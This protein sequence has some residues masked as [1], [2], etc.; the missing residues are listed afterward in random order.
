[1]PTQR[2]KIVWRQLDLLPVKRKDRLDRLT[3]YKKGRAWP[4]DA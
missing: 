2:D 3:A 4:M 1:M